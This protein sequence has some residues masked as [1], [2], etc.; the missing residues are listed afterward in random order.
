MTAIHPD[1]TAI[2]AVDACGGTFPK[3]R[4][5]Y[6][7]GYERGYEAALDAAMVAVRPAD[8]LT[9]DLLDA[10][11]VLLGHDETDE[12]CMATQAHIDAREHADA[13]IAKATGQ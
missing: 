10:L 6:D 9:A 5:D 2:R 1:K 11:A 4:N 7:A 8:A 3:A 13:L 12:G